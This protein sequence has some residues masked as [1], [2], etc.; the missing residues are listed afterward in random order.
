MPGLRPSRRN[1]RSKDMGI[2][3]KTSRW[4][5][6]AAAAAVALAVPV[7]YAAI[8]IGPDGVIHACYD[9]K[10]MLRIVASESSCSQNETPISWNQE[11]PQGDKGDKGD[12]GDT[13]DT[14]PQGPP[15][16]ATPPDPVMVGNVQIED[17]IYPIFS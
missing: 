2:H 14:G 12:K 9:K 17:A 6:V 10:G 7:A 13:G 15:G 1:R 16:D 8:T 5:L 11:G 3:F 4:K